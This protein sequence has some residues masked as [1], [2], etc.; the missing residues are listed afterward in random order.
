MSKTPLR[1]LWEPLLEHDDVQAAQEMWCSTQEEKEGNLVRFDLLAQTLEHKPLPVGIL[2]MCLKS[3]LLTECWLLS[4]ASRSYGVDWKGFLDWYGQTRGPEDLANEMRDTLTDG[5]LIHENFLNT[6]RSNDTPGRVALLNEILARAP[7]LACEIE[8]I[9]PRTWCSLAMTGKTGDWLARSGLD[10]E[11]VLYAGLRDGI[12]AQLIGP[13]MPPGKPGDKLSAWLATNDRVKGAW[14]RLQE[15]DQERLAAQS[16]WF[17]QWLNHGAW[18][19]S[20]LEKWKTDLYEG[21]DTT[22]TPIE[23]AVFNQPWPSC[24]L[25]HKEELEESVRYAQHFQWLAPRSAEAHAADANGKLVYRQHGQAG[26][27]I[28]PKPLDVLLHGFCEQADWV[29]QAMVTDEGADKMG[30]GLSTD[31]RVRSGLAGWKIKDVLDWIQHPT[32]QTWRDNH[33][34]NLLGVFLQQ[35]QAISPKQ[36]RNLPIKVAMSTLMALARKHP[37]LLA[38]ANHDGVRALDLVALKPEARA[39]VERV[40]L[41]RN[42]VN[43]KRVAQGRRAF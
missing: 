6:A 18:K 4:V 15:Q 12:H 21:R 24:A 22:T 11:S 16:R 37:E 41:K 34:N 1:D 17:D 30:R 35:S 38:E 19:G 43:P 25:G 29:R 10:V 32:W 7:T 23:H 9:E 39:N 36:P 28:L 14:E 31:W 40:L 8:D 2:D 13:C 26:R 5:V 42:V 33:G 20:A 3:V 27:W